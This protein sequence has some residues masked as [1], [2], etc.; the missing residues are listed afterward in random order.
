VTGVTWY[1]ANA[2]AFSYG[3]RLPT[4]AEWEVAARGENTTWIYP[5]GRSLTEGLPTKL[6]INEIDYRISGF[7]L[8][9]V[10][11]AGTSGQN[12]SGW[13]IWAYDGATGGNYLMV[14]LNGTVPDQ[15]AGYGVLSFT[16]A[17]H[18]ALGDGVALVDPSGGVAEFLCYRGTFTAVDGPAAGMT[19]VDIDQIIPAA[20]N[21][22]LQRSGEEAIDASDLGW[23]SA[24][25]SSPGSLN[26]GELFG[27]QRVNFV[28]SG[29]PFEGDR[30]TT[31]Q[32]FYD[33]SDHS[34]YQTYD[35]M[36]PSG[37]Y[38]MAGNAAEWV[39]DWYGPYST[40]PTQTNPRGPID[41]IFKVVR[42]G[43][44]L[45]SDRG[46]R[47]TRRDGDRAPDESF[48]SIGFRVAY[49]QFDTK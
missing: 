5:F 28:K 37:V 30:G 21:V 1:G 16:M 32:G 3:M 44:Y 7:D 34:G 41:G 48:P 35:G 39:N 13:Q 26:S 8:A 19:T 43:S 36:S 2:F 46:V 9:F 12:L 10:E 4:E 23:S 29:D 25:I 45:S 31:P 11:V 47:V 6:W 42:G 38:D 33:G 40:V 17:L 27:N 15:M 14:G 49:I 20:S 18:P 24:N 22:S